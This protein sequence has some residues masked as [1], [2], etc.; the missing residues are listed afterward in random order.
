MDGRAANPAVELVGVQGFMRQIISF[1]MTSILTNLLGDLYFRS[2][3]STPTSSVASIPANLLGDL[4]FRSLNSA[5]C[6]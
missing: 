6:Q 1:K 3:N 5:P 2:L 4:Y